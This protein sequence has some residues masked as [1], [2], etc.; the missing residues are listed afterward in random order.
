MSVQQ[1]VSLHENISDSKDEFVPVVKDKYDVGTFSLTSIYSVL[2]FNVLLFNSVWL[3]ATTVNVEM[4]E[5]LINV[6]NNVSTIL[7][8]VMVSQMCKF[9]VSMIDDMGQVR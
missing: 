3:I 8:V 6:L 5:N 4:H 1:E 7:I 2:L 9:L